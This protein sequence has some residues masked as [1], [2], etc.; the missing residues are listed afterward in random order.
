MKFV[1][2]GWVG[3]FRRREEGSKNDMEKAYDETYKGFYSK[4]DT[5]IESAYERMDKV[6]KNIDWFK[7]NNAE[8]YMVLL[9]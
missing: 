8:A 5:L 4:E 6:R 9:D 2:L 3:K 7:Q 1:A